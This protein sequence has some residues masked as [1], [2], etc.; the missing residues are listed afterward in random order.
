MSDVVNEEQQCK[1]VE[2]ERRG[3]GQVSRLT[4]FTN[5][6][7]SCDYSYSLIIPFDRN[8]EILSTISS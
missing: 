3:W 4:L 5:V 7:I 6:T 8:I 2:E 1:V